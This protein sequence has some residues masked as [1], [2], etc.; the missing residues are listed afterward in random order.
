METIED[1]YKALL[2]LFLPEELFSY[3]TIINLQVIGNE[4]HVYIEENNDK[5]KELQDKSLISKGFH[6]SVTIQDFPLRDKPVF[7]HVRRR[8][9]LDEDTGQVVS[10]DWNAVAKGT[11][12]TKDFAT[13]LKGIFGYLPDKQ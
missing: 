1:Q 2:K 11:R 4:V 5:P 12:L 7:L 6:S 13:F 3:F 8:R 9:W 10:R